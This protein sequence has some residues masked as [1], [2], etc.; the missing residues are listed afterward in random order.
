MRISNRSV[1]DHIEQT[2]ATLDN[3]RQR[4]DILIEKRADRFNTCELE[5]KDYQDSRAK[6]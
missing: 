2:T 6:R 1:N 5:A 3:T 4:L